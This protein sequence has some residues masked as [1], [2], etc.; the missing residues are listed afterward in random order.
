M[1][2]FFLIFNLFLIILVSTIGIIIILT[3]RKDI[4]GYRALIVLSGSM[5]PTIKTGSLIFIKKEKNYKKNDVVSYGSVVRK[6]AIVTHRIID[7]IKKQNIKYFILKGD[8]NKSRD[9]YPV[10]ATAVL[11][12]FIFAIPFLGYF[13]SFAKTP[14]GLIILIIIPGT[15]IIW[16]EIKNLKSIFLLKR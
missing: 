15:I 1:K 14:L 10:P 2:A 6:N 9:L 12:K 16:E 4:Y 11:G 13:I 7:I 5:E 3:G 8:A